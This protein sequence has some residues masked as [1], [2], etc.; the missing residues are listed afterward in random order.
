[1]KLSTHFDG[2]CK[3]RENEVIIIIFD[4]LSSYAVL[5]S[6]SRAIISASIMVTDNESAGLLERADITCLILEGIT[7]VAGTVFK[8]GMMVTALDALPGNLQHALGNLDILRR[9]A[10]L[11][12]E[13]L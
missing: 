7:T 11:T 9:D 2:F 4:A 8:Q 3:G 1:M 13:V 12:I 5:H 10:G 6:N